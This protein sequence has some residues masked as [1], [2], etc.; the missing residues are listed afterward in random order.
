MSRGSQAGRVPLSA[1]FPVSPA[2]LEH[3][4]LH[5]GKRMPASLVG[6]HTR[7]QAG[8]SLEFHEFR[9]YT[10]GDDVRDIDW[11]AS[12]RLIRAED[13]IVRSFVAER[14]V[15]LVLSLDVR[16]TM[17]APAPM[18]KLLIGRWL[19]RALA[20]I[21]GRSGDRVVAHR[22]FGPPGGASSQI[23]VA[24]IV[25]REAGERADA[26]V[27][28][29]IDQGAGDDGLAL[30]PLKP[31]LAPTA[32][33]VIITDLY[34]DDP[35]PFPF[36]SAVSRMQDGYRWIILVELDSWPMERA[37][38]T[39]RPTLAEPPRRE[40]GAEE[41]IEGRRVDLG[42]AEIARVGQRIAAHTGGLWQ[43]ARRG[44]LS[45]TAWRWPEEGTADPAG[46]FRQRLFADPTL[47]RIFRRER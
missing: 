30:A 2:Q 45:H 34:F 8:R 27:E 17:R 10:L 25:G 11:R 31:L 5:A 14:N 3:Y 19:V 21:A 12:A 29:W 1:P 9:H 26:A 32:I 6:A 28:R 15:L 18:P 23:G 39:G 33:W 22:L 7:R 13:Y 38:L 42:P 43:R 16:D 41:R 40:A 36:Q 47:R 4:R 37:W 44:G 35:P 46:F 24:K 20:G